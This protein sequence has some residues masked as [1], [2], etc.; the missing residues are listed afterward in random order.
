M[1]PESIKALRAAL[2]GQYTL[3]ISDEAT[4]HCRPLPG[5]ALAA[6]TVVDGVLHVVIDLDK[7]AAS[8]HGRV[9][10]EEW[11]SALL[12]GEVPQDMAKDPCSL[13]LVS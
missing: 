12:G 2:C 7:G 8:K 6:A 3:P 1:T 13:S 9:M 4:V 5:R 11:G 10:L